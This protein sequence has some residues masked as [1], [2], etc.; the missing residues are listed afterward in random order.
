LCLIVVES[1]DGVGQALGTVGIVDGTGGAVRHFLLDPV[2]TGD[3]LAVHQMLVQ[4][5]LTSMIAETSAAGEMSSMMF[6]NHI[7]DE[8]AEV[9]DPHVVSAGVVG[10]REEEQIDGLLGVLGVHEEGEDAF[11]GV[12]EVD[13]EVQ[14][15]VLSQ[16][17]FKCPLIQGDR[18][19]DAIQIQSILV[20]FVL[21]H[22]LGILLRWKEGREQGP[23]EAFL[24]FILHV[25]QTLFPD[26]FLWGRD[27]G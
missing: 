5:F 7:A 8:T 6:C 19:G 11:L 20:G 2:F 1:Q 22:T 12:P 3:E 10:M 16:D 17:F 13:I 18:N 24:I 15:R 14:G 25:D 23:L 27:V 21:G 9:L 4:G 26:Q